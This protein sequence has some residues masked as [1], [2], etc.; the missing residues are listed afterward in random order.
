MA[1]F[2][3]RISLAALG[4]ASRRAAVRGLSKGTEHL[5]GASQQIVPLEA[6]DLAASG[7]ASVD[8]GALRG[9]VS[10]SGEYA[11]IQHERSDYRHAGGRQDHFL[12]TPMHAE[13]KAIT[14]IITTEIR[15][16]M[17]R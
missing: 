5:L 17:Q 1:R 10:Y 11:V 9:A 13:A 7:T 4:K 15:R 8:A 12:S 3:G 2:R 6:G 16:G 14:K